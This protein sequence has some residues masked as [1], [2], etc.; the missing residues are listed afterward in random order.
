MRAFF[1]DIKQTLAISAAI[2]AVIVLICYLVFD[3]RIVYKTRNL[4]ASHP[5]ML[6]ILDEV[7]TPLYFSKV[8]PYSKQAGIPIGTFIRE[9]GVIYWQAMSGKT[10]KQS[11]AEGV[12][13]V[14]V[15]KTLVDNDMILNSPVLLNEKIA[16]EKQ[17]FA[18]AGLNTD[19]FGYSWI[20]RQAELSCPHMSKYC[21]AA[22]YYPGGFNS[23]N[24]IPAKDKYMLS[25]SIAGNG[26]TDWSN[27]ALAFIDS[28]D[29]SNSLGILIIQSWRSQQFTDQEFDNFVKALQYAQK[30]GIKIVTLREGMG[31]I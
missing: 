1:D 31:K 14:P 27:D 19:Y 29:V 30:I 5:P 26:K 28:V 10:L 2:T 9:D 18:Q 3:F 7:P 11:I 16:K 24:G 13:V 8:L 23:Y 25:G 4:L 6:V 21:K 17:F 22:I 15:L 12:E 20:Y